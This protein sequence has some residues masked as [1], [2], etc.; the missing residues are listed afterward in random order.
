MEFSSVAD[1]KIVF[2]T[3]LHKSGTSLLHRCI[4]RHPEISGISGT[5][6]PRDEGQHLQSVYPPAAKYGGP[7]LFG[8]DAGSYRDDNSPLV[9]EANREALLRAWGKHW[10]LDKPVLV[11]KS[12]PHLTQTRFLQALFPNAYFVVVRRH[13]VA[14]AITTRKIG[15]IFMRWIYRNP[16]TRLAHFLLN[17]LGPLRKPPTPFILENWLRCYEQ[18]ERDRIHLK[19]EMLFSFESMITFPDETLAD[20]FRFIGVDPIP[21]FEEPRPGVNEKY[22]DEWRSLWTPYRDWMTQRFNPRIRQF[23]YDL[24]KV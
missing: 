11:E 2:I 18:Y 19:R 21:F 14:N 20:I 22:L 10:D 5:D 6:A 24:Q 8:L 13:P 7:G 3:G 4:K 23:G 15:N 1:K 16:D 17:R 9:T 12:P